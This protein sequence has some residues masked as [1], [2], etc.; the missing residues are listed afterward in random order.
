MEQTVLLSKIKFFLC[1]CNPNI[2]SFVEI[3]KEEFLYFDEMYAEVRLNSYSV[4]FRP[5]IRHG[6]ALLE[7]VTIYLLNN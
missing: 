1:Q 6:E 4:V 3:I 2:C 5:I 7:E